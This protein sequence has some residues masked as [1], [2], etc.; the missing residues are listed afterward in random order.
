MKTKAFTLI[1]LLVVIAIIAIL[2]GLVMPSLSNGRKAAR[3]LQAVSNMRQLTA[4]AINYA[5][6]HDGQ[7]PGD[8]VSGGADSWSDTE[9]AAAANVWYN[10][11]PRTMGK[12]GAGDYGAGNH[13]AFYTSD[14]LAFCPTAVYPANA[15]SASQ[16]YFAIA[17]NS[18]LNEAPLTTIQEPSE[19]V[20][21]LEGGLPG[22]TLTFS[23]QSAYTGQSAV[24]ASR[25]IARYTGGAGLLSFVDG[26][27]QTFAWQNVVG[28]SGKNKGKAITPQPGETGFNSGTSLGRVV[29]TANPNDPSGLLP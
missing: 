19:T 6:E 16:P 14:N 21:F 22:E 20:L 27:A 15:S 1:E 17:F 3:Q 4:A 26:H 5:S 24:Y 2:V 10:I 18:K 13:S 7:V 8:K 12:L 9:S 29:W 28:T 11:L 23:G 25:F